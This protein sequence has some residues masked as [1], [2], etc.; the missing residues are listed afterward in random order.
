M[1]IRAQRVPA[2]RTLAE[3]AETFFA[4]RQAVGV[5]G[6]IVNAD[7]GIL[8]ACHATRPSEPWGLPGGWLDRG[9]I[10]EA[11]MLREV[12]EELDIPV[13]LDRYVGTHVHDNGRFRPRGLTL[14]YRLSTPLTS[15]DEVRSRT[16]EVTRTRWVR[17]EEACAMVHPR[18][19]V[20]IREAMDVMLV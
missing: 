4:P 7:G 11:G 16:W 20:K 9:E 13:R 8:M 18:T 5:L 15:A 3:M 12:A 2:L 1:L 6:V 14:V 17:F 19:A 10:P